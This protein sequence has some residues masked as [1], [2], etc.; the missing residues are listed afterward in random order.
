MEKKA[1]L[2]G[3]HLKLLAIVTMLID[4]I[5][6]GLFPELLA[7][8]VIGRL[9]FPIFAFFVC[10]GYF[11]THNVKKYAIRLGIFAL[12]SEIP[13]NLL[14][15]GF[16]FDF[17]GQNIFFTLL[18]GLL[19][20]HA[21]TMIRRRVAAGTLPARSPLELAVSVP[22]LLIAELLHTDYGAFGVVL[23]LLCFYFRDS[24]TRAVVGIAAANALYGLFSYVFQHYLPLQ[25]LAAAASVPLYFYNGEKGRSMKFFFYS[26]Y[27]LHIAAIALVK[28]LMFRDRFPWFPQLF[29]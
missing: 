23:I 19:T 29:R 5:G 4:H 22:A 25:A 10:E 28:Y 27:P 15:G 1:G 18:I 14:H 6:A 26:F 11:H 3:F 21:I 12:V 8:R 17:S 16:F 2:T 7:L 24:K 9:A 13:Y 20:I